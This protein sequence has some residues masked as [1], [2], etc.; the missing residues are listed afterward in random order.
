MFACLVRSMFHLPLAYLNNIL[1][2]VSCIVMYSCHGWNIWPL[3]VLDH[4]LGMFMLGYKV[5]Y[6]WFCVNVF[7]V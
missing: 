6:L 2:F 5:R 4:A 3:I 1:F 7:H